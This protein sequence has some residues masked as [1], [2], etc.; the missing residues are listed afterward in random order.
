MLVLFWSNLE[1]TADRLLLDLLWTAWTVAG[2]A[3]EERDLVAELG[4]AYRAYQRRV[5]M[6]L[7]WHRPIAEAPAAP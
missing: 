1:L 5:P 3:L 2:A 6:L 7:P 4:E